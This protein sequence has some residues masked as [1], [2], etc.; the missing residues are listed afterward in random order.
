M[1]EEGK[2]CSVWRCSLP[3]MASLFSAA[4]TAAPLESH[5]GRGCV[6][7]QLKEEPEKPFRLLSLRFQPFESIERERLYGSRGGGTITLDTLR[8]FRVRE[9][10]YDEQGTARHACCELLLLKFPTSFFFLFLFLFLL[11]TYAIR[12]P[13]TPAKPCS[14]RIHSPSQPHAGT[15]MSENRS[16]FNNS[17][18][19]DAQEREYERSVAQANAV[20]FSGLFSGQSFVAAPR[21][22]P[23]QDRFDDAH[24]IQ[25]SYTIPRGYTYTGLNLPE[26]LMEKPTGFLRLSVIVYIATMAVSCVLFI[27]AACPIPWYKG[28][29]KTVNGIDFK[30][31]KWSLWKM[32]GGSLKT[33]KVSDMDCPLQQQFFRAIAGCIIAALC[34]AFFG[35]VAGVLKLVKGKGSYGPLLLIGFLAFAWGICGN[36]MA[37]SQ[38]HQPFC[39][40]MPRLANSAALNAGFALSL[41]GWVIAMIGFI[42]LAVATKFNVGPA[43]KGIRTFDTMYTI[44][45]MIALLFSCVANAGNMFQRN[46][47]DDT[48][49]VVHIAYWHTEVVL[50]DGTPIQMARELYRCFALNKRIKASIAMLILGSVS[51]FFAIILSV[52]AFLKPTFRLVST[53]LAGVASVFLLISWII[54][55][56]ILKSEYCSLPVQGSVF[57]SYPGIPSGIW[58][59]KTNFPGYHLAEGVILPIIAWVLT[60]VAMIASEEVVGAAL[61]VEQVRCAAPE[62]EAGIGG[63]GPRL[64]ATN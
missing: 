63:R 21:R 39:S 47:D 6:A 24:L 14:S 17:E 8:Y 35:I 26:I 51:L 15:T 64:Y 56:V 11:V 2:E 48:V 28:K 62:M 4:Q 50:H 13:H 61:M 31:V 36:M 42:L 41:V 37:A 52:P 25:T 29:N 57:E 18:S 59:G 23:E 45:L 12:T 5:R 20:W 33:V 58:W 1:F 34:F 3:R 19:D 49:K 7:Q 44:L 54:A 53:I 43:L 55:V 9:R 22:E 16:P 27:I 40:P 32:E 10:P 30:D 38:Y 60:L 46:F